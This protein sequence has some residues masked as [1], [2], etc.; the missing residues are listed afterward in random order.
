MPER[1]SEKETAV[2]KIHR[3]RFS[4]IA[5]ASLVLGVAAFVAQPGPAVDAAPVLQEK[6]GAKRFMRAKLEA[7]QT[8]LEGL[9]TENFE[10]VSN[11]ARKM[12]VMSKA[13]EWQVIQG[14]IYS[15]HS[16]EFQRAGERLVKQAKE[17]NLEGATLA[18]MQLTMNCVTCHKYVRG[19]KLV[20][21]DLPSDQQLVSQ[22]KDLSES[23]VGLAR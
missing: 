7:S 22:L 10:Q 15:Q 20:Q 8:I 12:I 18:Y 4:V 9:V 11:G 17:K 23:A 6:P 19:A 2:S 3:F 1:S 14:P 21:N 13:A 5:V 16:A